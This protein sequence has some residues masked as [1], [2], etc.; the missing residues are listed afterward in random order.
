MYTALRPPA[1]SLGWAPANTQ[2]G[3]PTVKL[4]WSRD[5]NGLVV[6][7]FIWERLC[8]CSRTILCEVMLI[9]Y[10][11]LGKGILPSHIFVENS[12]PSRWEGPRAA[13]WG[14]YCEH[15]H[16]GGWLTEWDGVGHG[17]GT[18]AHSREPTATLTLSLGSTWVLKNCGGSELL[19]ANVFQGKMGEGGVPDNAK[20]RYEPLQGAESPLCWDHQLCLNLRPPRWSD[21]WTSRENKTKQNTKSRFPFLPP[22]PFPRARWRS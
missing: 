7:W 10:W 16:S 11:D 22:Y 1:M 13:P 19:I 18:H 21:F 14:P 17:W 20:C 12:L 15:Q 4:F 9:F 2:R 6:K 3:L 8:S 5:K